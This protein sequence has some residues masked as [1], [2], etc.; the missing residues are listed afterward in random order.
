MSVFQCAKCDGVYDGDWNE[1]EEIDGELVCSECYL[2]WK[3]EQ[4]IEVEEHYAKL[5]NYYDNLNK[6]KER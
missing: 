5:H 2:E 3:E 6:K 4:R 1:A